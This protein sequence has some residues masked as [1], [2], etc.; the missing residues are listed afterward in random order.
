MK[1]IIVWN[2]HLK[3]KLMLFLLLLEG[4]VYGQVT[5]YLDATGSNE[6]SA[7]LATNWW[8]GVNGTGTQQAS[9]NTSV[10]V[11]RTYII[12]SGV[13]ASL[14]GNL[15][16]SG[17]TSASGG[18]KT[19]TITILGSL[20][21][22]SSNTIT[23]E[24]SRSDYALEVANGGTINFQSTN[25]NQ[26]LESTASSASF[27]VSSGGT[28]IT[29]NTNGIIGSGNHSI[30]NGVSSSIITGT[31]N[32]AGNY[33][34]ASGGTNTVGLPATV[35]NLSFTNSTGTVT[36]NGSITVNGILSI[37]SGST[38]SLAANSL[39]LGTAGSFNHANGTLS[40]TTGTFTINGAYTHTSTGTLTVGSGGITVGSAG[41]IT[42]SSGVLNMGTRTLTCAGSI[43]RTSGQL[44]F[45]PGSGNITFTN[46]ISRTLP[47]NVFLQYP[48][49]FTLNG[50]GGVVLGGKS[51][52]LTDSLGALTLTSGTLTLTNDT[53]AIS[54]IT[55]TAVSIIGN[56]SATIKFIGSSTSTLRMSQTTPG[57]TNLLKNILL[58][59]TSNITLGNALR[60]APNGLLNIP[61]G[62]TLV[63]GGFL[64]ITSTASGHGRVGTVG[65][66]F[67]RS[68]TDSI[69]LYIPGGNRLFRLFG[70]PFNSALT[71]SQFTDNATEIDITGTGGATNGFTTSSSNNASAFSYNEST[72]LW[73]AFTSA[74]QTIAVGGGAHILVRGIKGEGLT[75]SNYTP[76]AATIR[77]AGQYNSGNVTV[78]LASANKGWNLIAN[79]YPSN[80]N[81]DNISGG[82]WSNVN[83]AI[84][85]YDK[86]NQTYSSYVKGSPGSSTGNLSNIIEMGSSFMA[87]VTAAGSASIT[88][89]ESIKTESSSTVGGNPIFTPGSDLKN[90]F[91][92]L[93]KG[94]IDNY[95][96]VQDEC[97]ISIGNFNESTTDF[98][99]RFDA[100]DL[101]GA[102]LNLS[103]LTESNNKLASNEYPSF[104]SINKPIKLAIWTRETGQ[105]KLL[106]S[107]IAGFEDNKQIW[108]KDNFSNSLHSFLDGDYSFEITEDINS[109]GSNRFELL[110]GDLSSSIKKSTGIGDL[111]VYPNPINKEN[112]DVNL[113]LPHSLIGHFSIEL[114]DVHGALIHE[115]L[116]LKQINNKLLTLKLPSSLS[117]PMYFLHVNTKDAKYYHKL[118]LTN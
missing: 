101:G 94:D 33:T 86:L 70:N 15:N 8:T 37:A 107:E 10:A 31:F 72:N 81:I 49:A 91:K 9:W 5:Y 22:P 104:E 63:T 62:T 23:L 102:L 26:W 93:L 61:S 40:F 77:L 87:E 27:T 103:I 114:Y 74:T 76:S 98:D 25:T 6:N 17:K 106:F 41:S 50:A 115:D 3:F 116:N 95:T 51:T 68:S 29:S 58:Q 13:L 19:T 11:D 52:G 32:T 20:T 75:G 96:N 73:T 67:T 55:G 14:T 56:A 80:I 110:F 42:L 83:N 71:L 43:S 65:G 2:W 18:N 66:T 4:S 45:T 12:P 35:N 54:S 78:N 34:F 7:E 57:V 64:T 59:G 69:Q 117:A 84:Y 30:A 28:L 92:I 60:I 47:N 36:L 1:S 82:N 79:P 112:R 100:R 109:T 105:F 99:G 89:T 90:R 38:V 97:L 108:L 118:I 85:G 46:T 53:T 21:I 16:L 88:F 111:F 113:V 39:I 48:S 44:Y 24:G